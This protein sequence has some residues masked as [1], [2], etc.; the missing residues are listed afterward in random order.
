MSDEPKAIPE[1]GQASATIGGLPW[2]RCEFR[3]KNLMGLVP[4]PNGDL[5]HVGEV[6]SIRLKITMAKAIKPGDVFEML[7]ETSD[8]NYTIWQAMLFEFE[9]GDWL[10]FIG[11]RDDARPDGQLLGKMDFHSHALKVGL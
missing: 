9:S 3:L 10:H 11:L 5:V 8:C 7:I 1:S 6:L 4:Q 2:G